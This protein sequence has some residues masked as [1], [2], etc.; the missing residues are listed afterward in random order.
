M[1]HAL[2]K[3]LAA[4]SVFC[5]LAACAAKPLPRLNEEARTSL[6]TVGIM[7]VGPTVGGEVDEPFGALSR[8]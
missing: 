4:I 2:A 6:G 8:H 5:G 7:T 1:A 3:S